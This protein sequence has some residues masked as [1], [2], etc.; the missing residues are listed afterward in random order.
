MGRLHFS[1]LTGTPPQGG[2]RP[3]RPHLKTLGT[4]IFLP[5]K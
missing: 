1:S 2:R 4:D 3:L 5:E